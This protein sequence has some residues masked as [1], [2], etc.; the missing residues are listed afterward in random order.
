MPAVIAA[1]VF[2]LEALGASAAFAAFL[3]PV[4]LSVGASLLLGEVSKMFANSNK[5]TT[6]PLPSQ[7]ASRTVTSRQAVAPRRVQY[8]VGR[9]GG[10][11]TFLHT[12]GTNNEKLH[13]VISLSGHE[14]FAI[15][16]MY[17]DGVAVPL[18][19]SG[20]ATGN[21]AG[22]VHAEF[23]LGTRGQ[24]SF[25]G[26]IAAAPAFWTAAHRQRGCAGAYVALTWDVNK[27]PNG[28]PNIT[29][30]VQGRK[31]YD[32]R[33]GTI[34]Y[35]ANAALCIADYLNNAAFVL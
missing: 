18:D 14:F 27:F 2:V 26:L 10:I 3:A 19:G 9:L 7:R 21:F 30:D 34:A 28:V 12:T 16:T 25:P 15:N 11:I 22:F 6:S 17:F 32:P 33:T 23:N 5:P 29:F 13:I 8:G 1:I 20:N 31:V 4:L 24:A 35:S